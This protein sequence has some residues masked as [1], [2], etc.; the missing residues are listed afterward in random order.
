MGRRALIVHARSLAPAARAWLRRG[1]PAR[2]LHVFERACNLVD[3][4]G[5][6][7]SVVTSEEDLNPVALAIDPIGVHKLTDWVAAKSAVR[8]SGGDLTLGDL[9]IVV[10][11]ALTWDPHPPWERMK[12]R[13]GGLRASLPT[14]TGLLEG[15]AP[16]GSFAPLVEALMPRSPVSA[17]EPFGERDF[18]Q[19]LLEAA[20]E[21]ARLICEGLRRKDLSRCRQGARG[22]SGLGGGLTPSGD[23]FLVG[24]MHAVWVASPEPWARTVSEA[25]AEV[26][27]A[28]TTPLSASWLRAAARGE[29]S[30]AWHEVVA[31]LVDGR[32]TALDA[33]AQ[34][35]LALGHTSGADALAGFVI[36]LQTLAA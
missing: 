24:A 10:E 23:D 27:A 11:G 4:Q 13:R 29:S 22:L 20:L 2:V 33:A 1:S 31:A 16:A 6:V 3:P 34:R 28:H 7:L 30:R 17:F 21:P 35:L 5:E 26:A 9:T 19:R 18:H 12:G 15:H 14:L 25:V 36:A 32:P 8:T